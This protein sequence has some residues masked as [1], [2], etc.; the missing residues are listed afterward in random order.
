MNFMCYVPFTR[1]LQ[2][3]GS[4]SAMPWDAK[5]CITYVPQPRSHST[6]P[7]DAKYSMSYEL[8][9]PVFLDCIIGVQK[10]DFW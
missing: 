1:A 3:D 8:H 7:W 6:M 10:C 9:P 2:N 5:V 4:H